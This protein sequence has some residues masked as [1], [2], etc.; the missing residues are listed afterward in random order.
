RRPRRGGAGH[1]GGAAGEGPASR[2][3]RLPRERLRGRGGERELPGRLH[4]VPDRAPLGPAPARPR[5]ERREHAEPG[6]GGA[7]GPSSWTPPSGPTTTRSPWSPTWGP[8][9][10]PRSG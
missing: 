2:G 10:S 9:W 5:A 7:R 4:A 3:W 1:G 6:A 8:R